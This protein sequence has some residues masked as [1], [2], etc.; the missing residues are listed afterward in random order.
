[1]ISTI[2]ARETELLDKVLEKMREGQSLFPITPFNIRE[3]TKKMRE[4]SEVLG[5]G[6]DRLHQEA[7]YGRV[8]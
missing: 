2:I 8:L 4:A 3:V 1:M 7:D 6:I 5:V